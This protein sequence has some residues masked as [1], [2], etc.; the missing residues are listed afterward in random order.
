MATTTTQGEGDRDVLNPLTETG[1][2][3]GWLGG[4]ANLVLLAPDGRCS[5]RVDRRSARGRHTHREPAHAASAGDAYLHGTN[6]VLVD[7]AIADGIS[8][9]LIAALRPG[10]TTNDGTL[11]DALSNA[12]STT[13]PQAAAVAEERE[14]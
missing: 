4:P 1:S 14:R 12:S 10:K 13:S 2:A 7:T 11:A 3:G 5:E 9:V 6:L 8:A